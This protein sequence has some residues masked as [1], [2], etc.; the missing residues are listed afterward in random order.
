MWIVENMSLGREKFQI[1]KHEIFMYAGIVTYMQ[2]FSP[3]E[4]IIVVYAEEIIYLVIIQ[5][6]LKFS[7]F[8]HFSA[9]I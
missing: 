4:S 1:S 8:I 3:V 6:F 5:I 2:C 9:T 7:D